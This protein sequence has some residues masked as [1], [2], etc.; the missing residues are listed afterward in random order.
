[1]MFSPSSVSRCWTG[2]K[3][4][5]RSVW[6]LDGQDPPAVFAAMRIALSTLEAVMSSIMTKAEK[7]LQRHVK[8]KMYPRAG[9]PVRFFRIL[10]GPIMSAKLVEKIRPD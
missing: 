7:R 3:L 1:M 4:D 8:I 2:K 6:R 10:T 9:G 5:P